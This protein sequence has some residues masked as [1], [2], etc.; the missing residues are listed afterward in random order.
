MWALGAGGAVDVGENPVETL[1]RE[2]RDSAEGVGARGCASPRHQ[3]VLVPIEQLLDVLE[4]RDL[5]EDRLQP[6]DRS[7]A[8]GRRRQ[9]GCGASFSRR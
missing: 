8:R 9:A 7:E 5:G 2:A 3:H 6:L 4:V 1:V